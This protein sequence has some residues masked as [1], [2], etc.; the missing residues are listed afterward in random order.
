MGFPESVAKAIHSLD[1]HWN[2]K[3]YPDGLQGRDIPLSARILNLAQTLDVFRVNRGADAAV[4]VACRRSKRWF[5]PE[6]VK[7]VVA[8]AKSGGLWAGLDSIQILD[9]V[10]EIEPEERRMDLTEVRLDEICLAF[11]EVIDAKSPF[12]YR[13]SNGVADAA[14]AIARRLGSSDSDLAFLRRAALLHDVGKL[15][16]SNSI[17]EKPAKLTAEEWGIMK[18]HPYHSRE[19]LRRIAGFEELSEIA[20]SHHEKLDGTGY[21]RRLNADQLSLPARILVVA[22]IFDALS[23]KRP[24]RDA[25]PL[26]TVLSMLMKDAP[27]ALDARCVEALVD[28]KLRSGPAAAESLY[29]EPVA[30]L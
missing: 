15:G 24:Y 14:V 10:A 17:L 5:D 4:E 9:R 6:L 11:A 12:T 23:A 27:H 18:K 26:E 16:V 8:L 19:I 22:D 3:G 2:G 30:A 1:E 25:L 21:Y 7:A 29:E 28:V 13:H 20:A